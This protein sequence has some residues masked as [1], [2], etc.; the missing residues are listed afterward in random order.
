MEVVADVVP[1]LVLKQTLHAC[2][3]Q[4]NPPCMPVSMRLTEREY[5]RVAQEKEALT[6][7]NFS[8]QKTLNRASTSHARTPMLLP[9]R[10]V[11]ARVEAARR[12]TTR[13]LRR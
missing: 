12:A 11:A 5:A 4:T 3:Y 10:S 13:S 2:P 9:A 8:V 1:H 7:P 6:E